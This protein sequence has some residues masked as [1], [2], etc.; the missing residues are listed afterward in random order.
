MRKTDELS[1]IEEKIRHVRELLD[2]IENIADD[3]D[4]EMVSG[5]N[6]IEDLEEHIEYQQKDIKDLQEELNAKE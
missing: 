3:M 6:K 2:E 1:L 4:T 5:Q